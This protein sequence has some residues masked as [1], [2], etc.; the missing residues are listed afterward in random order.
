GRPPITGGVGDAPAATGTGP[1]QAP[2]V[3]PPPP[4]PAEAPAPPRSWLPR[5]EIPVLRPWTTDEPG[6][7][8]DPRLGLAGLVLIPL[9]GAYLGY[10]QA[11]AAQS[12]ERLR[13]PVVVRR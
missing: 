2:A 8:G 10:R 4:A 7:V 1:H 6:R 5:G 13:G 11:R 12:A 3:E 9:A